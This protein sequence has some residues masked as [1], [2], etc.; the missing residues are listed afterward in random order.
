M[1]DMCIL[2]KC[3]MSGLFLPFH[4][5]R[6]CRM[7][8]TNARRTVP[9]TFHFVPMAETYARQIL[10]WHYAP[11]YDFYNPDPTTI[12]ADVFGVFLNPAYRY[13]AVLDHH[14]NLIAHR[15]FGKDA[16]VPG[17]DYRADALDM[18]GGLRPTLTGRGLGPY[19]I[20][21]AMEFA[22]TTFAPNAFRTTVAAW[23]TRALRACANVGYQPVHTFQSPSNITFVILMRDL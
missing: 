1:G 13:Y 14:G 4:R 19:V 2:R 8:T 11:P 20:R 10:T 17:G 22:R 7:V 3:L 9:P 5:I 18:G 15:C 23:N 6:F 16:Q 21:A 12:E